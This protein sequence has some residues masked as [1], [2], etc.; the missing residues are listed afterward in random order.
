ML[1]GPLC[2]FL[3]RNELFKP[4]GVLFGIR[5][6]GSRENWRCR[7]YFLIL[8]IGWVIKKFW[9]KDDSCVGSVIKFR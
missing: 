3:V 2:L 6:N 5:L 8:W 4:W 7:F 1:G 9:L